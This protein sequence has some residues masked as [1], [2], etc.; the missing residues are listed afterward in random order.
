MLLGN[1]RKT[2]VQKFKA[3]EDF[4]YIYRNRLDRQTAYGKILRN[5]AFQIASNLKYDGYQH[6]VASVIYKFFEFLESRIGG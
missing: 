1:S 3:T 5:K 2:R 6:G 4:R